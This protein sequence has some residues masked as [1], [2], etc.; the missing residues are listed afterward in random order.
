[1]SFDTTF[2]FCFLLIAIATDSCKYMIQI[3]H[4]FDFLLIGTEEWF[5]QEKSSFDGQAVTG[6][7][8]APPTDWPV[9]AGGGATD[10][11]LRHQDLQ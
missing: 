2:N 1:M 7:H 10:W 4:V 5:K 9:T 11:G 6:Q 3:K 8:P